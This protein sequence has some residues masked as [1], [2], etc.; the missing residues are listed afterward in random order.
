M[1]EIL[2]ETPLLTCAL[3]GQVLFTWGVL[4]RKWFRA[5]V[6]RCSLS[7]EVRLGEGVRGWRTR[8]HKAEHGHARAP[9]LAACCGPTGGALDTTVSLTGQADVR[10]AAPPLRRRVL[11]HAGR[12]PH[13]GRQDHQDGCVPA[14]QGQPWYSSQQPPS[15]ET[16]RLC[17]PPSSTWAALRA[18][19]APAPV[20]HA[21]GDGTR[22]QGSR[23]QLAVP[24]ARRRAF[25]PSARRRQNT[26]HQHRRTPRAQRLRRCGPVFW[27]TDSV[28]SSTQTRCLVRSTW[29]TRRTYTALR[30]A[31]GR[32]PGR[33]RP[34]GRPWTACPWT[35]TWT[36]TAAGRPRRLGSLPAARL[37]FPP[38]QAPFPRCHASSPPVMLTAR[39][40][41]VQGRQCPRLARALRLAA[42][43]GGHPV[44]W[45]EQPP[46]ASRPR[47]GCARHPGLTRRCRS[48]PAAGH[49]STRCRTRMRRPRRLG[50]R[51][52]TRCQSSRTCLAAGLPARHA[53]L[54]V[55]PQH[56]VW[57]WRR[58][59][60][61]HQPRRLPCHL[62]TRRR[63]AAATRMRRWRQ[64]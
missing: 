57:R 8:M 34:A 6:V 45:R 27:H 49:G 46:W 11:P 39:R 20:P 21:W 18:A 59:A 42:R 30:T 38:A 5:T 32:R 44:Q 48:G 13:V 50:G 33:R 2:S 15:P 28:C 62:W 3:L 54:R 60:A 1:G 16:A 4:K 55:T 52:S 17:F 51:A 64:L 26:S 12:H 47:S 36:S 29:R 7:P 56:G 43:V 41:L 24:G 31:T 10:G 63:T 25:P 22:L 9:C 14:R 23:A 37:L 40:S 61:P 58:Q 53:A 35:T 19:R